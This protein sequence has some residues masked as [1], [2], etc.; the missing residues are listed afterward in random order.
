MQRRISRV[1]RTAA[2]FASLSLATAACGAE[3]GSGPSSAGVVY[4]DADGKCAA[5][6]AE[7]IDYEAARAFIEPFK[8]KATELLVSEALPQ[9]IDPET[10]V[11][12]LD[13]GSAVTG[14][15]WGF[16][17]TAGKAAGVNMQRVHTGHSAQSINAALGTVVES[18]P[19]ILIAAAV[20]ATFFQGQL[21]A[22]EEAGTTV[23]YAG[24]TNADEFGLLDSLAGHGASI[25]NGKV[26]AAS[27]VNFTCGTGTEYVFYHVPEL[28]FS[29]VQLEAIRESFATLCSN[30]NLRVVDIPI[31][32]R[33][34]TAGDAIVSD[35]QA[36]PE[37]QYF[38]TGSDQMQIGLKA[39]QELA[40]IDVPGIGHSSL[41]SNV[42]Q[43]AN[44]LQSAGYAADYNMYSWLLL[45]EGLRRHMGEKVVYDD[46]AKATQAM[47]LVITP[48]N[49][50]EYP[51]GFVAYPNMVDDFKKLWGK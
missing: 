27:A 2:I 31:A 50:G 15:I 40:G 32:T 44:G 25:V 5:P 21:K 1:L 9:P 43:I 26:L 17:E 7:G 28:T 24:S 6:P 46:W 23:V 22:L 51:K 4:P 41:P 14:M 8:R 49:A 18:A 29:H 36:H 11:A 39:K 42:E 13:S 48:A 3:S 37:T 34:T 16:L 33:D 30:C 20:D 10:T 19:D 45:D 38:M 47:S 12:F 35:L